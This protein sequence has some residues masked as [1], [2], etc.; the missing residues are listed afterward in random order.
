MPD[1]PFVESPDAPVRERV[2]FDSRGARSLF[3]QIAETT[4]DI[5]YV[6]DVRLRRHVYINRR[7]HDLL[8]FAPQELAGFGGD[9]TARL[10][11][12]DDLPLIEAHFRRLENLGDSEIAS[13]EYR[14]LHADGTYRWLSCRGTVFARGDDGLYV[15]D[16]GLCSE[17]CMRHFGARDD[18]EDVDSADD[19]EEEAASGH[20]GAAGYGAD[21]DDY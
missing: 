19:V 21:D 2:V 6:Y 15:D 20:D 4:P 1:V 12:P 17:D 3:E 14:M 13:V 5:L 11:H 9:L 8:G 18:V 16:S 7:V 10:S